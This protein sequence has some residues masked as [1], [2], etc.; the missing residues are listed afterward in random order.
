MIFFANNHITLSGPFLPIQNDCD[1]EWQSRDFFCK[2]SEIII[3]TSAEFNNKVS[4]QSFISIWSEHLWNFKIW[5]KLQSRQKKSGVQHRFCKIQGGTIKLQ[6]QQHGNCGSGL[7][8]SDWALVLI[9]NFRAQFN[10]VGRAGPAINSLYFANAFTLYARLH[11]TLRMQ[12]SF[13]LQTR[14]SNLK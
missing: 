13:H 3:N 11:Q 7:D 12:I 9:T 10:L 2:N 6:Q 14:F 8:L 1:W 4:K 5:F